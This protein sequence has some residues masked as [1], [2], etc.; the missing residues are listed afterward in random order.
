MGFQGLP[1]SFT[2]SQSSLQDYSDCPRRFQLRY[3]ENFQWP[4]V[5]TEPALENE[6]HQL[7][8]Q[9]FHRLMQQH[10]LGIP[11]EKLSPLASTPNL[12]RWWENFQNHPPI[13]NGYAHNTE[14][15]L[16]APLGDHFRILAKY[17]LVAVIYNKE[18]LVYDWKTYTK[19]PT[20]ER[21]IARWQTRLYRALLVMAGS[22]LNNGS[23][24][25]PEQVTMYYW[26][27]DHPTEPASFSY[28]DT[29]YDRDC[30]ALLE[31]MNEI[32]STADFP[33]TD[34][35]KQCTFCIYRSYC[36]RMVS[37]GSSDFLETELS[38]PVIDLEQIQEIAF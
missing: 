32:A 17:D 10:Y 3:M 8:G 20:D 21:M 23:P 34:N 36:E 24:V 4:A 14:L 12:S 22:R 2:F 38:E 15:T 11:D 25:Q 7:E 9:L 5:E 33:K 26:Y 1:S 27:A 13:P 16:S 30:K 31:L 37:P 28:S 19:R 29:Q 35:E 6:L 18:F